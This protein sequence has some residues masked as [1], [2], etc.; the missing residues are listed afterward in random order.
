MGKLILTVFAGKYHFIARKVPQY[1]GFQ[2]DRKYRLK[3]IQHHVH[4]QIVW[5]QKCEGDQ[6]FT[7][8]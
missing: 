8:A 1:F 4:E 3:P 5:R 6:K 2:H 7:Y